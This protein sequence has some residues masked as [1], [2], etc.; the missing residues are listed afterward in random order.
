MRYRLRA[1]GNAKPLD[2]RARAHG[3]S[4]W[5]AERPFDRIWG[6]A[7]ITALVEYKNPE[8]RYGKAGLNPLQQSIA[9]NWRGG[10]VYVVSTVE[11]VDA[12]VAKLRALGRTLRAA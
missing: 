3:V 9:D 6:I 10:P 8:T 7:G 4:V 12:T 5:R 1:D 2:E 11:E